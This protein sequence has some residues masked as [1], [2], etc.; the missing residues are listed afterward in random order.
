M[1]ERVN[2][3]W[4]QF[5][6]CFY[7]CGKETCSFLIFHILWLILWIIRAF[8]SK[9]W[10]RGQMIFGS[11]SVSVSISLETKHWYG[12]I[13][14]SF[15]LLLRSLIVRYNTYSLNSKPAPL[16]CLRFIFITIFKWKCWL[17]T[18]SDKKLKNTSILTFD[19]FKE[20]FGSLVFNRVD[21]NLSIKFLRT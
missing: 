13:L 20:S 15:L 17:S 16:M 6:F 21:R 18:L 19:Y 10:E 12:N 5:S 7:F 9:K 3:I 4:I 2:P 14:C 1:R 8:L 11:N